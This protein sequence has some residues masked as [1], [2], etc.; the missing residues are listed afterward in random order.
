[1]AVDGNGSV[2]WEV[3]GHHFESLD[4]GHMHPDRPG[5]QIL[6][7]LVPPAGQ[8]E[9]PI[10]LLHEDGELLGQFI[11]EY[12]RFHTTADWNND[13][14]EEIV[15]PFH[16]GLFDCSG[17]RIG[18]FAMEI[19][20]DPYVGLPHDQG[21]IGGIV[22]RGDFTGGGRDDILITAPDRVCI[23]KNP[24]PPQARTAPLGSHG[25]FTLY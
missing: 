25:N 15:I 11:V 12:G 14:V 13:G 20:T 18:T 10:W 17:R 3:A 19:Q 2:A 16:R 24:G 23:F 4:I 9:Y 22:M 7:D 6:V 1:M 8:K 5:M 21:E